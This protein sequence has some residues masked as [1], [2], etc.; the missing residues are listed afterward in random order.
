[1]HDHQTA[2]RE[3][4]A[5]TIRDALRRAEGNRTRAAELA[6]YA[7]ASAL[8]R[9]AR[10]AGLDLD[11]IPAP[12]PQEYGGLRRETPVKKRVAKKNHKSSEG[13]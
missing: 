13:V 7:D 6:G 1:M 3:A 11:A 4:I 2:A 10:R 8:R 12:T 9:A 5:R